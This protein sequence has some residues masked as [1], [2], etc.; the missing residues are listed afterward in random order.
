M[1][2]VDEEHVVLAEA[3]QDRREIARAFE[4]RTGGRAN[5]HAEF[6]SDDVGER[7]FAE[8]GRSVEQHVIERLAALACGGYR[9]LQVGAD[10]LLADVVVQRAGPEPRLVL[11]VFIDPRSGHKPRVCHG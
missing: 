8:A 11:D 4:H 6:L 3:R 2:L 9:Y 7:G 5:R 1:N 10:T